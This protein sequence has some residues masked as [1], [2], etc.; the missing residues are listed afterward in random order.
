MIKKKCLYHFMYMAVDWNCATSTFYILY[1]VDPCW[2]LR[3]SQSMSTLKEKRLHS[4]F[5]GIKLVFRSIALP[6]FAFHYCI[7]N[8]L[9]IF[10]KDVNSSSFTHSKTHFSASMLKTSH[11][12]QLSQAFFEE[13]LMLGNNTCWRNHQTFLFPLYH[14]SVVDFV[15]QGRKK[16]MLTSDDKC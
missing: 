14:D 16:Q 1:R 6:L 15:I 3:H 5:C 11:G 7:K 13:Y 12:Q 10:A 9:A 2:P 4:L 8:V